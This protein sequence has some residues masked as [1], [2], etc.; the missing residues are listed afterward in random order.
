MRYEGWLIRFMIVVRRLR[1][2]CVCLIVLI[3][4]WTLS[5]NV[6]PSSKIALINDS[7][8]RIVLFTNPVWYVSLTYTCVSLY[9]FTATKFLGLLT[10]KTATVIDTKWPWCSVV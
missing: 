3:A 6:K 7:N 8:V 10:F 1:P 9:G 4:N 5:S 2:K